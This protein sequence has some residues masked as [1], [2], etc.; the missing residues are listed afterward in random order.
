M[1]NN[2]FFYLFSIAASTVLALTACSSYSNHAGRID[3]RQTQIQNANNTNVHTEARFRG[4]S[5]ARPGSPSGAIGGTY[6]SGYRT[7]SPNVTNPPAGAPYRAPA[8]GGIGGGLWSHLGTFGAGMLL[9]SIL[10]PFGGG[11]GGYGYG[12]GFS[13]FGTIFWIV[14][15]FLGYKALRR[16]FSRNRI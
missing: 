10:H 3:T 7:P 6:H 4:G 12:G 1:K 11:Y 5:I 9:G 15:L 16:L 14:I 8:A 13:L 2:L